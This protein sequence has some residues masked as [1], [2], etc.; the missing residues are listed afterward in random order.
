M[1][2]K[3]KDLDIVIIGAGI[4]GIVFLKYAKE[5]NFN[6]LALEKQQ[7]VGGLWKN[8]PS[9]QDIQNKRMDFTIN[10]VPLEGV[11]Q[12]DIQQFAESWVSKYS[13]SK[14][15]FLDTEVESVAR[16][17]ERWKIQTSNGIFTSDHLVLASGIHNEPFIPDVEHEASGITELHSSQ[18]HH[19]AL[20]KDKR[21][22]IVGGGTSSWDLCEQALEQEP[23][24]IDWI[25][26]SIKW[27]FPTGGSK[28]AAWPNIREM[29]LTQSIFRS[30]DSTNKFLRGLLW[31]M[32]KIFP[33]FL[34]FKP[35]EK[36]DQRKHQLAPGRADMIKNQDKIDQHIG[37]IRKIEGR[38]LL[39]SN[40]ERIETDILLWATGYEIDLSYTGLPEYEYIKDLDELF[41][42]LGSLMLSLD[43]PNM[44]FVGMPLLG[45]TSATPFFSAVES[46]TILAHIAGKCSI[47]RKPILHHI[48][49]WDLFRYFAQFDHHNYTPY[50]WKVKYFLLAVWYMMAQNRSV[51][52]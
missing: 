40:G 30:I 47:P 28:Q 27:F 20:L 7:Q 26:R 42:K 46:K 10:K 4:S 3:T 13:L 34:P 12:G 5:Y 2:E 16:E 31:V 18:L 36:F 45:S 25:Y 23:K 14:D 6:C 22:T 51:R 21:V 29:A 49:H 41:P 52:V 48:N 11:K 32:F 43:Y 17:G 1:T 39:L 24:N 50:L 8:L 38:E 44:Y 15:I 37:E 19:P 33:S 9:W 35:K